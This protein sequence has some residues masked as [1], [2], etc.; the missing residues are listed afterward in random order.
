V[1]LSSATRS[2]P[3]EMTGFVPLEVTGFVPLE[4]NPSSFLNPPTLGTSLGYS[5]SSGAGAIPR[6]TM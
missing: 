2:I 4:M 1:M 3:L 5:K 6:R